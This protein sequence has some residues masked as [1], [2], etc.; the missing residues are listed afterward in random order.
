MSRKRW[1]IGGIVVAAVALGGWTALRRRGDHGVQVR[2]EGVA[3][4]DLV[5]TVTASG[6]IQ[7]KTKVDVSAD[8]TGRII[9]LRVQEGDRVK[10]GDLLLRIDPSTFEAAVARAEAGL[11]SAQAAAI[12]A[13]AS[14]EQAERAARRARE[15]REQ[16]PNLV[17]DEQLEQA[18]T[19]FRVAAAVALSADRQV[20]QSRA[21]LQEARDQLAKTVL[22]APM[23]GQVTRVAVEEG[24]VAVPGTFSRETGLL[25]TVSDLSVIQVNVQ[26]DETDVVRLSLG[27][28]SEITIDA[29]PDTTFAGRVTKIS[30]SSTRLAA[31]AAT[32]ADRAVD[33]DVEITL[34]NPPPDVRPDLSATAKIVTA[35]RDSALSIP[36]IALTVREHTP[37]TSESAPADTT[38]GKQET[39]GVFIVQGGIAQFRPVKVGIAGE[40]HFEV[41]EGLAAGDS[42]VAGPYQAIRDLRDSARVRP[43]A[44]PQGE[45]AARRST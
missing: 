2:I 10:K 17:S 42:I 5:S 15:L 8:I 7:P 40:E 32:A 34:D 12:Q 35:T 39:E 38:K 37:I 31:A 16:N 23:D 18:E 44:Q 26:V 22:R 3:R 33:Y 30:Q 36:I 6:K 27:D 45:P 20:D 11:A 41:L 43:M 24:E 9:E 29:F 13:E 14:R 19:Q 28:S 25:M 4:R 1:V 21:L